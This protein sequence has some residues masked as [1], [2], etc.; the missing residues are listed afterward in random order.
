[1]SKIFYNNALFR[2][3]TPGIF[4]VLVY[5]LVL[6]IFDN[7]NA[8]S[9]NFFSQEVVLTVVLSYFVFET[10]RLTIIFLNKIIPAERKI[11]FRVLIQILLSLVTS[12]LIVSVTL[13]IYFTH[14]IG[15]SVFITELV[16]FNSI[17]FLLAIL[18]NSFFFSIFYLHKHGEIILNKEKE[19][20]KN[21]EYELEVYKN[22]INP[23]FLYNSLETLISIQKNDK[24]TGGLYIERLA[25]VY[26]N[27][28][29]NRQ[30]ELITLQ[31]EI[32]PVKDFV[33]LLN[34]K[35]QDSIRLNIKTTI[36]D[37]FFIVPGTII[38]LIENALKFN[39]ANDYEK[40]EVIVENNSDKLLVKNKTNLR[41]K[42]LNMKYTHFASLCKTYSIY[43]NNIPKRDE[44]NGYFC[45]EIPLLQLSEE[46]V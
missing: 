29:D 45:V 38:S 8:I 37:E 1:M 26:R 22:R 17:F 24:P 21:I 9:K 32:T 27:T 18:Y 7:L 35:F 39:L 6:L 41:L 19:Q 40:L 3:I 46:E 2:I 31:E 36:T 43:T 10:L 15:F 13:W 42:P 23:I 12:F 44:I 30:N 14:I 16:A 4:G 11:I 25:N 20:R 5:M 34:Q 28:L 33:W